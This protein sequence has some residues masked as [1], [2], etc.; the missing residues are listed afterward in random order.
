MKNTKIIRKFEGV[1]VGGIELGNS[2]WTSTYSPTTFIK[3]HFIAG[4]PN[5]QFLRNC[6]P[7]SNDFALLFCYFNNRTSFD[8][9]IEGYTGKIVIIVGP[10]ND[11]GVV[12]DPL[13][14]APEFK[15]SNGSDWVLDSVIGIGV[16]DCNVVATYRRNHLIKRC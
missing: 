7:T 1:P 4:D 16:D 13:P 10:K 11:C 12:T 15:E 3:L 8:K 9:Y 14:L 6:A 2:W 5:E